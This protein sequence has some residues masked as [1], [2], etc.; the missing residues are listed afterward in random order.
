M[1]RVDLT[2]PGRD[3]V[4]TKQGN[5]EAARLDG[6]AYRVNPDRT[7]DETRPPRR[8]SVWLSDDADRVPLRVTATTELGDIEINLAEY[9]RP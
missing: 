5:R 1:W 2:Y 6:I 9:Q 3:T 8:F 7:L 4:G